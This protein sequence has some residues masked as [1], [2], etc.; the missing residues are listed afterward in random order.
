M[1]ITKED[2]TMIK[3]SKQLL[4]YSTVIT[5]MLGVLQLTPTLA[6]PAIAPYSFLNQTDQSTDR[7]VYFWDLRMA[8]QSY[9][10][11]TNII[12]DTVFVHVQIFNVTSPVTVCEETDFNDVYTPG[13]THV[14][15]LSALVS[16]NDADGLGF[17]GSSAP[18]ADLDEGYGLFVVSEVSGIDSLIGMFRIIDGDSDFEY[19]TN[20]AGEGLLGSAPNTWSTA[21]LNFN[22]VDSA[23]LSDVVG[24]VYRHIDEASVIASP[25][26]Q[27]E[28]GYPTGDVTDPQPQIHIFDEFESPTSCSPTTF[29][30]DIGLVDKGIDNFH[31]NSKGEVNRICNDS[32]DVGWLFMPLRDFRCFDLDPVSGNCPFMFIQDEFFVG[33][34]G[35]NN[36]NGTGSMDSWWTPGTCDEPQC[37]RR[38]GGF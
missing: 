13:D 30:C 6:Q 36:G 16:N 2:L 29:A 14:Y 28:F 33:F 5:L 34:L 1:K 21:V 17:G 15:D 3:S 4:L 26:I 8:R 7:V 38:G 22:S 35:L 31:P 24:L 9:V 20:A 18:N 19:R 11:V 25:Q 27:A 23:N 37:P 32:V 12:Q 10:Q